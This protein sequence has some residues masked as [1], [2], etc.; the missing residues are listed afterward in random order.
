LSP[1]VTLRPRVVLSTPL[2]APE[3]AFLIDYGL[4]I[5]HLVRKLREKANA[6]SRWVPHQTKLLV[7]HDL[8]RSS[9]KLELHL[10]WPAEV[11]RLAVEAA[12]LPPFDELWV[13]EIAPR[14]A[15]GVILEDRAT[16]MLTLAPY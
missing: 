12:I 14:H 11:A 7:L 9:P 16:R 2:I 10:G 15:N 13:I 1:I 5:E 6:V 4:V 3:Q 8:P